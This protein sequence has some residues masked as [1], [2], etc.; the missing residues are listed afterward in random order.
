MIVATTYQDGQIFQHF[1]RC[2]EFKLYDIQDGKVV[3]SAVIG[4]NGYT[5]G[6]LVSVLITNRVEVLICGGI[7]GGA[8][9]LIEGQGIKL[10][11]G[12]QGDSDA[13][14]AAFIAGS[15]EYDPDTECHHH[16][17]GDHA[18]TCGKH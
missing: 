14:V 4:S 7:G 17:G 2:E 16:D 11:P 12:A 8:R 15:L 3:S 10:L 1:G 9:N 6:G 5:H 18:C 13:C